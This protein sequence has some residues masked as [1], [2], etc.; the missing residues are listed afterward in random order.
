[1]TYVGQAFARLQRLFSWSSSTT[2]SLALAPSSLDRMPPAT[3]TESQPAACAPAPAARL[4]ELA[5][6]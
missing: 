3:R 2:R 6:W 5:C 1:M 4:R